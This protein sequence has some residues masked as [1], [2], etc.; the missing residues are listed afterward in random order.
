MLL[1]HR[2]LEGGYC[3]GS[4][5]S[6]IRS[7]LI[8]AVVFDISKVIYFRRFL[9]SE[10]GFLPNFSLRSQNVHKPC[11]SK[12]IILLLLEEGHDGY[13]KISNFILIL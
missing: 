9:Y 1:V 10:P 6:Q 2:S 12:D 7:R 11:P 4:L 8:V 5:F 13:Q 3:R